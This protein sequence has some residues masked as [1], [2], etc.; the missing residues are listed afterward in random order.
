MRTM[1]SLLF[2]LG[3]ALP[4]FAANPMTLS[5]E[6]LR[7][8]CKNP[9][10]F[11]NQI[12][13][14]NIRVTCKDAQSKWVAEVS[15]NFGMPTSRQITTHVISDKYSTAVTTSAVAAADQVA[16]CPRFKLVTETLET[17]RAISCDELIAF[18][19]SAVDFCAST[20]NGLRESNPSA[21]VAADDG[22]VLDLCGIEADGITRRPGTSSRH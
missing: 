1:T 14:T 11:H 12:A 15:R 13:P 22:R 19:G 2:S 4:V 6:D 21:V 16:A 3:F 8:A 9:T 17:V 7:E 18:Q 10:R 5:F 20:L